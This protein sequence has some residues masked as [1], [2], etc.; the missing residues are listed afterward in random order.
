MT[1]YSD[2]SLIKGA[3][4][5]DPQSERVLWDRYQ[6]LVHKHYHIMERQMNHS[7]QVKEQRDDFYSESYLA[8]RKAVRAV[9]LEKIRDDKWKFVG[10][11]RFYIMNLR[12]DMI[13][14]IVR[15]YHHEKPMVVV[16]DSEQELNRSDLQVSLEEGQYGSTEEILNRIAEEQATKIC[17]Q[18]WDTK[19]KFIFNQKKNGLNNTEIAKLLDVNCATITY[20]MQNMAKDFREA[21]DP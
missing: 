8:F 13:N 11:F 7:P 5:G 10:Y 9:D 4:A 1:T 14:Q 21:I 16:S 19:K 17:F 2:R 20:H 6:N 3:K 15:K 18:K 12:N